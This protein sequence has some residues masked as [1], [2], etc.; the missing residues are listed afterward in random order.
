MALEVRL[1]WAQ[2]YDLHGK[3]GAMGVNGGMPWRLSPD[4]RYFKA[5][6]IGCPI[7]MGRTTWQSMPARMRPL[8]GRYNIVVSRND[9]FVADGAHVCHSLQQAIYHARAKA[10]QYGDAD[11]PQDGKAVWIIG[12]S[13]LLQEALALADCAY[14]TQIDARVDADTFAPDMEQ[15]HKQGSW[16]VCR[17]GVWMSAP[18]IVGGVSQETRYRFM[19]YQPNREQ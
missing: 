5:M 3:V 1:I 8:P 12:G 10:M 16:R 2:A 13:I 14:V 15:Y 19:V 17:E 4:L 7:I 18:L 9:Q 11:E 6:T